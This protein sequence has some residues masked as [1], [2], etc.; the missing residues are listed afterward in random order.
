MFLL[1]HFE[2]RRAHF[3]AQLRFRNPAT[4]TRD[5]VSCFLRDVA[6]EK[7]FP[8]NISQREMIV[9]RVGPRQ[10]EKEVAKKIF[11]NIMP[12]PY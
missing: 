11:L 8:K 3:F 1:D 7:S 12:V 4:K 2:I 5:A 9:A 6:K 10:C